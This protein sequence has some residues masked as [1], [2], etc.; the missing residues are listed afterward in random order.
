VTVAIPTMALAVIMWL[1]TREPPR[2][3][4]EA[5]LSGCF[6]HDPDGF[7]YSE[8]LS[9]AKFWRMWQI[10]SNQV[11]FLQVGTRQLF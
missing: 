1:T 2:G 11:V 10:R 4:C 6:K 3:Q 7:A 9:L 8:K 5:A